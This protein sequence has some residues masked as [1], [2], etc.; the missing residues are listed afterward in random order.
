MDWSLVLI[1]QG[2]E[3]ALENT[4]E[5]GW[6]L[7]V[8]AEDYQRALEA[9]RLYRVENRGWPWQRQIFRA[10]VI[11]DWASLAWVVLV[12]LFFWLD[13]HLGLQRA[14]LMNSRAVGQGEWWRLFTAIWL[15]ADASHLAFNATLGFL[16][17]GLAMAGF[18]SGPGLLGAYLAGM[19]G[20][21]LGWFVSPMRGSSLGASGMV[22]GALG[23][24]AM[25]SLTRW[26]GIPGRTKYLLAGVSGGL[27]LFVLL[28]LSPG[29]DVIAHLG[30]FISGSLIGLLLVRFPLDRST[31]GNVLCGLLFVALVLLPWWLALRHG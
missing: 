12:L 25:Q 5:Q 18:G 20:N 17:L 13:E 27:M 6:G 4:P 21:L 11:F 2:I 24:L 19:G 23:L 9:I 29:T 3:S 16:L 26:R 14:G 31:T 15:H 10:G 28:G 30:G 22:M 8:S 7:A 1:S